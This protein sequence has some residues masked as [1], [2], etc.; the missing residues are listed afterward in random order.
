MQSDNPIEILRG[1]TSFRNPYKR[2]SEWTTVLQWHIK[3]ICLLKVSS[4]CVIYGEKHSWFFSFSKL[5]S[6]YCKLWS[7]FLSQCS[8]KAHPDSPNSKM[9]TLNKK[10]YQ[11]REISD[12]F[13]MK[14]NV[15]SIY[16]ILRKCHIAVMWNEI[17]WQNCFPL[18]FWEM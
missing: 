14:N 8:K 6:N 4:L 17:L 18:Q 2:S 1:I 11:S 13:E 16:M 7:D 3:H 15:C 10:M 9:E 5:F 12:I